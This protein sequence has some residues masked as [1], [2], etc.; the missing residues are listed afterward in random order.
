MEHCWQSLSTSIAAEAKKRTETLVPPLRAAF[1]LNDERFTVL[2][3]AS[4]RGERL[5]GATDGA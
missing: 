5:I 1:L 4:G 3:A 2:Q